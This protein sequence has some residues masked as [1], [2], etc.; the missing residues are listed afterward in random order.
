MRAHASIDGGSLN[1]A[2]AWLIQRGADRAKRRWC[3]EQHGKLPDV[4]HVWLDTDTV[5]ATAGM[6]RKWVQ[7][8]IRTGANAG[9]LPRW[10]VLGQARAR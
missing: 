2:R 6:T 7:S 5:A 4:D 8:Q 1:R 10:A 3:R 9:D